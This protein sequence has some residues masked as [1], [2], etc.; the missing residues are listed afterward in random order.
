MALHTG[1]TTDSSPRHRTRR[2]RRAIAVLS[3][4]IALALVASGC[5]AK[6]LFDAAKA[7]TLVTESTGTVASGALT[8]TSGIAVSRNNAGV[9][10]AHNDSGD[11]ARVFAMTTAGAHLGTFALTGADAVDWEDMGL[12][13]GPAADKTYLYLADIGDNAAT[14]TSVQVYRALEP[15]VSTSTPPGD[16]VPLAADRL[17]FTYP[18]GARDAEAFFV[19][20]A[21]GE[22]WIV[23]KA[24]SG[25]A[26]LYRAPANLAAGST[27]VLTAE[28][29]ISLGFANL[30]TGADIA[31]DGDL[32]A[33]RTYGQVRLYWRDSGQS[34]P[35]ALAGTA[36]L[37]AVKAEP[38]GEAIAF[39]A[40][41]RS[42]YTISEAVNPP[43]NRFRV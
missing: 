1:S 28:G 39:A 18:D 7:G 6:A 4:A 8:E 20:P 35:A 37:G 13:P 19:D 5:S 41:S 14:R 17:T 33:L 42:Y 24:L 25:V 30:V 23:T 32:V 27:T 40:D 34:V 15:A 9:I 38:Q 16:G 31:L 21:T 12:G 43:I 26:E 10:W 22:L 29:S 2:L 11:T 3:L 36:V